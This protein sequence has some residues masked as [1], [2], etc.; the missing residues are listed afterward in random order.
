VPLYGWQPIPENQT[1]LSEIL[2][3]SGYG[4]LFVTD[5]HPPVQA[6][7]QLPPRLRRLPFRE[8]SGDRPRQARLAVPGGEPTFV[9]D[10]RPAAREQKAVLRQYFAN[11][12]DRRG[13][14]DWG[15]PRVFAK[16]TELL[17]AAK[18][19][20]PFFLVV[21]SYDPHEPWDPPEEYL[22]LYGDAY[23]GP[24]PFV[25]T[26]GGVKELTEEQ[27]HRM[28]ARYAA[29]V[30]MVDR[31]FGH[32]LDKVKESGLMGNTLVVLIAD[33]GHALGEHG[34]S[35][36]PPYALWPEVTD[37]P[38]LVRHP[39]GKKGGEASDHYASTHDV[40]PTILGSLGIRPAEPM[41]GQDL[42][43]LFDGEE[44]ESR[45]HFTLGYHDHAWARD[46]RYV[47]FARND[48]TEAKLFDAR[49]DLAMNNDVSGKHSD[50]VR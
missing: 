24:E 28:R 48:G 35:G 26:Y 27:L 7:L 8:G 36:K 31:W 5:T 6:L 17:T 20:Q 19:R 38:F 16:A 43:V 22:N 30:T 9:P 2:S 25:P 29:E 33:H 50:I 11:A 10:T 47:M 3:R 13:E 39:K 14:E 49:E 21:D 18:G 34:I 40:A 44:P 4:T 15:A 42:S 46:D 41:D 23:D 45:A 37:I 1:M 32:F 12:S